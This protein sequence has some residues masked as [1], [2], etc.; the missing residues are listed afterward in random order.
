MWTARREALTVC[1][2]VAHPLRPHP[3]AFVAP[4]LALCLLGA[5]AQRVLPKE[6]GPRLR[7]ALQALEQEAVLD[8]ASLG[9]TEV[10]L[11][12]CSAPGGV[13][14]CWSL[15]LSD[16]RSTCAGTEAGGWCVE[17]GIPR[18]PDRVLQRL[19][20]A[21]EAHPAIWRSLEPDVPRGLLGLWA[22]LALFTVAPLLAGSLLGALAASARPPATRRLLLGLLLVAPWVVGLLEARRRPVLGAWDLLWLSTLLDLGL[23]LGATARRSLRAAL[24]RLAMLA[25]GLLVGL[26]ILEGGARL[27]GEAVQGFPPAVEAT[28]WLDANAFGPCTSVYAG[29]DDRNWLTE[30][31]AIPARDEVA[32]WHIGDSMV[33]GDGV[34]PSETFPARMDARDPTRRHLNL[35]ESSVGPDAEL[36][37]ALELLRRRDAGRLGVDGVVLYL[38]PLNDLED[39]DQ[40]WACCGWR[41][42]LRYEG[43]RAFPRCADARFAM[44]LLDYLRMSPPPFVARAL[45]GVSEA[46]RRLC[47]SVLLIRHAAYG[48]GLAGTAPEALTH[49]EAILRTLKAALGAR[50]IPSAVVILPV[51]QV[52][53]SSRPEA[54]PA[55]ARAREMAAV[56]RAVGL[57][58]I[59]A[60]WMLSPEV[61]RGVPGLWAPRAA[62]DFHFGPEGHEQASRWL[63]PRII[64]ALTLTGTPR[65]PS[66]P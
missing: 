21:L 65:S 43:G 9:E 36:L 13:A 64:E 22:L 56:I 62:G 48:R 26:A 15:R 32:I 24:G 44:P 4:L 42:L 16:P 11:R 61:R 2:T 28:P 18:P 35:S 53:E 1:R 39:L 17:A 27:L 63:L 25:A 41:S 20:Q 6:A 37:F 19:H 3:S 51:R 45:T 49:L 55:L 50:E 40:P 57:P 12:L 30:R 60:T 5:R 33:F 29:L 7:E 10:D 23:I 14:P 59:D 46:A 58:L 47:A 38:L 54:E 8:S 34:R 52:L 66:S 31:M